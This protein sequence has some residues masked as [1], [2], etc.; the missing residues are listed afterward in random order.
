MSG[1]DERHARLAAAANPRRATADDAGTLS[2]LFAASFLTDP[3]FDYIAR[4]GP[5]RAVGLERFF[6]WLLQVRA[7]PFGEV[8]MADDGAVA[9]AWL[10]P[11]APASPGGFLQQLKLMPLFV[12]LCGF[13]RLARGS[14]MADAMEKSHPHK[15]HFYLAFI[16][17]APRFQGMG[18]GSAMLEA[19]LNRIDRIGAPAYLE[20]SNP[21]NA[22]LY[23]RHN[24]TARKNIS[25]DG[26][27]PLIAMWRSP[28]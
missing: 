11:D 5:K 19:N 21:K 22:R 4:P 2:R 9:A 15:P 7:I 13:P 25:P 18:L 3:V 28:R 24:F 17:V 10:P 12:R 20:N 23:E 26:A 14:A 6:Y 8:W 16:A 1:D 27:P